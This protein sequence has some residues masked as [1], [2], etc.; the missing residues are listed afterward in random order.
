MD[1]LV[2]YYERELALLRER[3][4]EFAERYPKIATRLA[5][6]G[7]SGSEDPHAE[8]LFETFALLA[9]RAAKNIEDDY[10]EFT[11]ALIGTLYPH[12]LRPFPSCSIAC[13]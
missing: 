8:R 12:Y 2:R 9:A 6:R 11:K 13:L 10:P 7:D 4:R 1:D 5:L 3:A